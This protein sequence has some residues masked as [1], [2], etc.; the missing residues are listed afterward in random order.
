MIFFH[1]N[2]VKQGD[3]AHNGI[4]TGNCA[5][6]YASLVLTISIFSPASVAQSINKGMW[7]HQQPTIV[8][9]NGIF[10]G[11]AKGYEGFCGPTAVY[12]AVQYFIPNINAII[13][14]KYGNV[15]YHNDKRGGLTICDPYCYDSSSTYPFE[16]FIGHKYIGRHITDKGC[17]YYELDSAL[18]RITADAGD[19]SIKTCWV[20]RSKMCSFLDEGYL[21]IM[22]SN[23]GGG[24]YI[25]IGGWEGNNIDTNKFFYIW[26]GWKLPLD[27][28]STEYSFTKEIIGNNGNTGSVKLINCYKIRFNAFN[29]I[30]KDQIGDGAMLAVKITPNMPPE[31]ATQTTYKCVFADNG[32]NFPRA[33]NMLDTLSKHGITDMFV[34]LSGKNLLPGQDSIKK[35]ISF[36]HLNNIKVHAL[37]NL[38]TVSDNSDLFIECINFTND[39]SY[40]KNIFDKIIKPV[41]N[42]NIDGIC[43]IPALGY[44]KSNNT[45]LQNAMTNS[46]KLIRNYL[47]DIKPFVQLGA[48]VNPWTAKDSI[49]YLQLIKSGAKYLDYIIPRLFTHTNYENPVWIGKQLTGLIKNIIPQCTILAGLQTKDD[50][51]N[52]TTALELRQSINFSITAGASGFVCSSYPLTDW[53]WEVLDKLKKGACGINKNNDCKHSNYKNH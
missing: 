6:F 3:K 5:L 15:G 7:Y 51:G 30:F 43:I 48:L 32:L 42:Y 25:L 50:N 20:R 46:Y 40:R 13:K 14:N 8:N 26:D 28:D 29:R 21:L 41:C 52:H 47:N 11:G 10:Y 44:E 23:Q 35:I 27:I 38:S 19:Y 17:G 12:M 22:N 18:L 39:T 24:H 31:E 9:D 45:Q 2:R 34:H 37:V 16:D 4:Q 36:A 33:I 49:E 53:Q 1:E